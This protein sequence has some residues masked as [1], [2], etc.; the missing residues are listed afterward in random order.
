MLLKD[1]FLSLNVPVSEIPLEADV[2][3]G[4][5]ELNAGFYRPIVNALA[6]GPCKVGDLLELPGLEGSRSS[7][8][9]LVGVLVGLK[10]AEPVLRPGASKGAAAC[11]LNQLSA[12]LLLNEHPGMTS[13]LASESHGAGIPASSVDIFVADR[14]LAGEGESS[15]DSWVSEL[16]PDPETE[17]AQ[18]LRKELQTSLSTRMPVLQA[19]GVF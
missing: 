11:R 10:L 5:A 7:P 3:A 19:A 1:V 16:S 12:H 15:L 6:R 8:A 17:V 4:R 18:R 2:P 9:E 14:I 13:A